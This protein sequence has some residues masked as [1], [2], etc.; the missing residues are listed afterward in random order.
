MEV[1]LD[2]QHIEFPSMI[3]DPVLEEFQIKVFYAKTF[4][5]NLK[6][7]ADIPQKTPGGHTVESLYFEHL[8]ISNI[9]DT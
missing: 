9:S 1:L 8:Y 2:G 5:N 7:E 6:I 3:N 4:V